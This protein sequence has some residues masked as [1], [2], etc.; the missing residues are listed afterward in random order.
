MNNDNLQKF[1]W[2]TIEWIYEP[3]D[4]QYNLMNIG[5]INVFPYKRQNKHVHYSDEQLIY[6]LSGSGKQIIN[7]KVTNIKPG[8]IFHMNPGDMHETINDGKDNLVELLI[9]IPIKIDNEE[10]LHRKQKML[11]SNGK[12]FNFN[13]KKIKP[14]IQ[15]YYENLLKPLNVPV[16][17][18]DAKGK[19]VL[20]GDQFP[21]YCKS[22][23]HIDEDLFNCELYKIKNEYKPPYFFEYTSY[24]C[25]YGI[26]V[27]LVSI[28]F[29][30]QVFGHIKGGHV[31]ESGRM[32]EVE[33]PFE[34]PYE[35]PKSSMNSLLG[36]LIK[37]QKS[38]QNYLSLIDTDLQLLEKDNMIKDK[39]QKEMNLEESLRITQSKMLNI[40][41]NNHFLFNTLSAIANLAIN[42]QSYKTYDAIISLSKM[43]RYNLATAHAGVSFLEEINYVKDYLNL[44]KIRFGDKLDFTFK[45]KE[46]AF[47]C[48]VPLNFLQ[49][50]VE[51]SFTH[52]FRNHI[53]VM[54]IDIFS[55]CNDEFLIISVTDNGSGMSKI[56]KDKLIKNLK[57]KKGRLSGLVM[58]LM[59]LEKIYGDRVKFEIDT[60]EGQGTTMTFF[61]PKEGEI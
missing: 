2:G 37:F 54:K 59:K 22:V 14:V 15:D 43:F 27:I 50:I 29:Q 35:R 26:T 8:M 11:P 44:Q 23:C 41:I 38:I 3:G 28:I 31:R 20:A 51:N 33:T 49:P 60:V 57:E 30:N 10:M 61:I 47:D 18:F 1:E 25:R 34:L 4:N 39:L 46:D 58:I 19:V 13:M 7:E 55:D 45:M 53:D 56:K 36:L 21:D 9:S 16:S 5:T 32:V 40:Q 24:V 17:V 48:N 52:G 12:K 6:V 42:D